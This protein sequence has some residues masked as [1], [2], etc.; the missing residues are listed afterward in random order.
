LIGDKISL[1]SIVCLLGP[2]SPFAIGRVISAIIVDAFKS[3]AGR[4]TAHVTKEVGKLRPP[5]AHHDAAATI[6]MIIMHGW[7]GAAFVHRIP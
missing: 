4:A 2:S 3:E 6:A 1:A 5:F 7:I